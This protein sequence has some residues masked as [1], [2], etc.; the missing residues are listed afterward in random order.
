VASGNGLG[1]NCFDRFADHFHF[2]AQAL[3]RQILDKLLE[4]YAVHGVA[5]F[6]LPDVLNC[7]VLN[8]EQRI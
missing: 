2:S 6:V 7:A 5:Q 8:E 3:S 4:K 1:L